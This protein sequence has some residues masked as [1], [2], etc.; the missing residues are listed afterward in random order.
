M[1]Q[2]L[3]HLKC[4]QLKRYFFERVY[5][6]I[7]QFGQEGC[8]RI[9]LLRL[10]DI[11]NSLIRNALKILQGLD[12]IYSSAIQKGRQKVYMYRSKKFKTDDQLSEVSSAAAQPSSVSDRTKFRLQILV[13]HLSKVKMVDNVFSLRRFIMCKETH[14]PFKIDMK[15][16]MRLLN[17]LASMN[18]IK[19]KYYRLS[20]LQFSRNSLLIFYNDN[21]ELNQNEPQNV[22]ISNDDFIRENGHLYVNNLIKHCLRCSKFHYF[23][24]QSIDLE[25]DIQETSIEPN[26]DNIQWNQSVDISLNGL[27]GEEDFEATPTTASDEKILVNYQPSIARR[28]YGCKQSKVERSFQ[29]YR[30]LH[31]LLVDKREKS[32][33]LL[34]G[35]WRYYV[36]KLTRIFPGK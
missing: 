2:N 22:S 16:V 18:L 8:T 14:L 15:T 9:Q 4:N 33:S 3:I 19:I 30:F 20:Y 25:K 32:E 36:P 7:E 24:G 23:A 13:E 26:P 1:P 17:Q 6:L 29:L 5:S 34:K 27:I 35:D 31:Y 11:P 10:V 21:A 12:L 28:M